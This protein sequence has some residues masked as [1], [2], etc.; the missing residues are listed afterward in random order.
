MVGMAV[1]SPQ[2]A[3]EDYLE[4]KLVLQAPHLARLQHLLHHYSVVNPLHRIQPQRSDQTF[5]GQKILHRRA[6]QLHH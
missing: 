4:D 2:L 1:Q 6:L 5:L 3:E